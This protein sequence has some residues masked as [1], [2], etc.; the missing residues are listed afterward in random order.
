MR[1]KYRLG[2]VRQPTDT[3]MQL[4]PHPHLDSIVWLLW[5]MTGA[6]DMRINRLIADSPDVLTAD[7]WTSPLT[8]SRRDMGQ[9]MSNDEV[10]EYNARVN[11]TAL[12]AYSA[13]VGRR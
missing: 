4:R 2:H 9:G 12:R 5:D 1:S 13:V 3:Q 7:G 8:L 11:T 10:A 6:K